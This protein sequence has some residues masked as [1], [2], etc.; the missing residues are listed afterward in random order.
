MSTAEAPSLY[1]V[2]LNASRQVRAGASH[3]VTVTRGLGDQ[4]MSSSTWPI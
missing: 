2:S 1:T 4:A 3:I